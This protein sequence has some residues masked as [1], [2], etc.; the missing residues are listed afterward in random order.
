MESA[1]A[2][3]KGK[4]NGGATGKIV[5]VIGPTLDVEFPPEKLPAIMNAIKIAGYIIRKRCW[6][7]GFAKET[8]IIRNI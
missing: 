6:N 8:H 2:A 1:S 5:Q 3:G 7:L 4:G